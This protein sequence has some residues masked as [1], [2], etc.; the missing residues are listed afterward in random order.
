MKSRGGKHLVR[1]VLRGTWLVVRSFLVACW[2]VPG[3]ALASGE[4]LDVP[5]AL[6]H[7]VALEGLSGIRLFFSE[8]YNNN[9]WL[10]AILCTV[11]MAAVG[12]A[13]AYVTDLLL[14]AMGMEV[15]KIEHRE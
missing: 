10:Y 3:I 13:I 7:K 15:A 8:L 9:L 12:M 1:K 5:E 2:L 4:G 14:K 11:L 6:D